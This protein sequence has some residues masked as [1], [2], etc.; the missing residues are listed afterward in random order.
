MTEPAPAPEE[1]LTF[2]EAA[3][4]LKVTPRTLKRWIRNGL[5]PPPARIGG[6]VRYLRSDL[7]ELLRLPDSEAG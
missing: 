1:A 7:V 6:S 3:A 4:F 5:I 2:A